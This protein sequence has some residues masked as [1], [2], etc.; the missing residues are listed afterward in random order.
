[1]N[2]SPHLI[3]MQNVLKMFLFKKQFDFSKI[4]ITFLWYYQFFNVGNE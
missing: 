1:M 3:E 4:Y 2:L